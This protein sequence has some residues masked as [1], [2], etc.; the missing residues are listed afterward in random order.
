MPKEA[1]PK[2]TPPPNGMRGV[3]QEDRPYESNFDVYPEVVPDTGERYEDEKP[4]TVDSYPE[5]DKPVHVVIDNPTR[6]PGM[7]KNYACI[8]Y[9]IQG[10][11][12]K[13]VLVAGRRT[14]RTVLKL[15]NTTAGKTVYIGD[16]ADIT[17]AHDSYPLL[18]ATSNGD[19]HEMESTREV[20]VYNPDA[21]LP[22]NVYLYFEYTLEIE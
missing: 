22:V 21:S 5:R 16:S 18:P 13:A 17:D 14:N 12:G 8:A 2:Y 7:V 1:P 15:I 6:D 19:C 4:V 9:T 10:G 20:W 11:L 3:W